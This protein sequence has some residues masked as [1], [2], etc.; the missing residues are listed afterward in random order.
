M[1][2]LESLRYL[3]FL[4]PDGSVITSTNPVTNIDDYPPIDEVLDRVRHLPHAVL[5]DGEKLARA[6]GSHRATNMVMVGAASE[7]LPL[8]VHAL[9]QCIA[10]RFRSKGEKVV[11]ANLAAFRAGREAARS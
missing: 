8:D 1:E 6:A 10:S 11:D 9:E 7:V 2:P 3:E 4:S 5:V